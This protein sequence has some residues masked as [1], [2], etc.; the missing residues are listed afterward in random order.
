[1]LLPNDMPLTVVVGLL[2]SAKV[3]VPLMT[4]HTPV[5]GAVAVLA[6]RVTLVTGAQRSWSGPAA[7]TAALRSKTRMVTSSVVVGG[8][9]GPLLM[10]QRNTVTP[11]GMVV[12]VVFG[13][14]AVVMV[15]P[16][17]TMVQ[18]PV[19]GGVE[20]FAAMVAVAKP[21]A[22]TLQR[23]WS[24]PATAAAVV[25][26]KRVMVTWSVV[27]PLAQGPLFRVHWNTLAPTP[28]PVTPLD[29]VVGLVMVPVPLT[30]VH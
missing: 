28:R 16:P 4:V 10:V 2:A 5:P 3:P 21:V 29:G 22:P 14:F 11:T 17:E 19:A 30:R 8:V 26:S 1:M 7:A 27:T 25:T 9:Q 18:T 12:M 15:P 24:G 23:S 13:L 6:A 20:A